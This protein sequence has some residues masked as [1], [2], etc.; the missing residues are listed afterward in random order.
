MWTYKVMVNTYASLDDIEVKGGDQVL[1]VWT[2]DT[3]SVGEHVTGVLET[4]G[5]TV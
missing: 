1:L 2:R 3:V 5:H 4:D